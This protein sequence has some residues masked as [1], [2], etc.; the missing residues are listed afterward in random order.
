VVARLTPGLDNLAFDAAGRLFVS[1]FTDGSVSRVADDGT[2][3]PLSPA[4]MAHPGGVAVMASADGPA[5]V[6]VADLHALRSF[7]AA[8]GEPIETARNILG[9]GELGGVLSVAADGRRLLLTAFTDNDVRVWDPDSG[10]VLE[11]FD[12]LQ[13]PVSAI[14]YGSLVAVAEHGTG[15][16]V[17]LA[18]DVRSILAEDLEAPTG[19]ATDGD[20]LF[21]SDRARGQILEV[22]RSG[23]ASPAR[24]VVSGLESPEGLAW[25]GEALVVVE[26]ESGRVLEVTADGA[27][28]LLAVVA[29]GT[30]P[31]SPAQPP[32]MVFNGVAALGQTLFVTGETNRV[33]YRIDLGA[34]PPDVQ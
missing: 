5:R 27:T 10:R 26:G 7:D 20:R 15:R 25:T 21:V 11:R 19:L 1:S 13:A 23:T 34:P 30:L 12:D 14:R 24:I 29:P 9:V 22:A 2:I 28:R 16:V 17:G 6:Y 31:A 3:V 33:L 32:S 4:G 8:S 18:G